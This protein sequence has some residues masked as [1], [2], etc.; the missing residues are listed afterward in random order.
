MYL[1]AL[2]VL[3]IQPHFYLDVGAIVE[4]LA[5][6]LAIGEVLLIEDEIVVNFSGCFLWKVVM[7]LQRY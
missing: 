5:V 2:R 3:V 7:N 4:D 6:S 1:L